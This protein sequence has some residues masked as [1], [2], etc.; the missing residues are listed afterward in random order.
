MSLQTQITETDAQLALL[1][2]DYTDRFAAYK[3][4]ISHLLVTTIAEQDALGVDTTNWNIAKNNKTILCWDAAPKPDQTALAAET[5]AYEAAVYQWTIATYQPWRVNEPGYLA[6]RAT[7]E[8]AYR[9]SYPR[10]LYQQQLAAYASRDACVAS[11]VSLNP[12]P[13][14]AFGDR[15]RAE[16]IRLV[17]IW[18]D[19][20]YPPYIAQYNALS[21]QRA[22]LVNQ[23]NDQL[24]TAAAASAS[25]KTQQPAN[26]SYAAGNAY[27]PS[28]GQK[29]G[30][31]I[32]LPEGSVPV[33]G[34]VAGG[35]ESGVQRQIVGYLIPVAGTGG[36]VEELRSTTTIVPSQPYIPP[37]PG[38]PATPGQ[39]AYDYNLGWN[40]GARSLGAILGNGYIEFNA[41]ASSVDLFVGLAPDTPGTGYARLPYALRFS[42]GFYYVYA[43]GVL[44]D[45]P[46]PYAA[47]E[48]FRMA[49]VEGY[50]TMTAYD[51]QDDFVWGARFGAFGV[52]DGA[53]EGPVYLT[54]VAYAAG[55]MI[56]N[57]VVH[58]ADGATARMRPA[59]G[60]GS[61]G[62]YATATLQMIGM[63]VDAHFAPY[64]HA[65]MLAADGSAADHAYGEAHLTMAA[66][67]VTADAGWLQTGFAFGDNATAYMLVGASGQSGGTGG[68]DTS[69]ELLES[70]GAGHRPYRYG[71]ATMR[72]MSVAGGILPYTAGNGGRL[73]MEPMGV[74]QDRFAGVRNYGESTTSMAVFTVAASSFEGAGEAWTQDTVLIADPWFVRGLYGDNMFSVLQ[75]SP[76]FVCNTLR[77]ADVLTTVFL[78]DTASAVPHYAALMFTT[79]AAGFAVPTFFGDTETWVMNVVTGANSRY[80]DYNFNSYALIAGTYYGAMQDGLFRLNGD[81]DDGTPIKASINFG[82]QT[83][84]TS[85][86]KGCTNAYVGMSSAGELFLKVTAEGAEYIY[87]ARDYDEHLQIQR[88]DTGRGLRA[89]YLQFELYS[90][91][92]DFDISSVEFLAVP[93]SRRI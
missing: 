84:G 3:Q 72:Y 34:D 15:D 76:A 52:P 36:W 59:G 38:I 56:Q 14:T 9:A 29:V 18:Q 41:P 13:I 54:V 55:D 62:T 16:Y 46:L 47:N 65:S 40:S 28:Y 86:L 31:S 51:P 60:V 58:S 49:Q 7:A 57:A 87:R 82:N 90:D 70:F 1:T 91:G 66:M 45:G 12:D 79:V 26:S 75:V 22:T 85:A 69:A 80:E 6:S 81:T 68:A 21:A 63:T 43:D 74:Y 50:V 53:I 67:T 93:L 5:N 73:V 19:T 78:A 64:A 24:V 23:L 4:S 37:R 8:A 30:G 2:A 83:F 10:P 92:A 35:N 25:G 27:D 39:L 20:Y 44:L 17:N 88:F 77:S 89:N 32:H 42:K 33:Y 48:K 61:E 11:W 71:Y